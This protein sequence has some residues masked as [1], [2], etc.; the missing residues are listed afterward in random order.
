MI[1]IAAS[2]GGY[3]MKV[4]APGAGWRGF[5]VHARSVWEVHEAIDH[6]LVA[7]TAEARQQHT[8]SERE[9]C[10]LCRLSK[11]KGTMLN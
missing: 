1:Q 8:N 11:S 7:A 9:N 5:K 6:H 10:P 3:E 2:G 4:S